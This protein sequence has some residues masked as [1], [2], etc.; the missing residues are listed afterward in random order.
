[1]RIE[2]A[3]FDM[4]GLMLDTETINLKAWQMAAKEVGREMSWADA[5][6]L[7]GRNQKDT[8]EYLEAKWGMDVRPVNDRVEELELEA[9]PH[10]CGHQAWAYGAFE[11]AQGRGHPGGYCH[12]VQSLYR[13]AVA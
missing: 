10:G 1:M 11:L 13:G 3:F 9:L 12:L 2:G 4:D 8:I 5:C 7:L 6:L